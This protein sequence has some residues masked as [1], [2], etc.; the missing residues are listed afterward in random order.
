MT[1]TNALDPDAGLMESGPSE[2]GAPVDPVAKHKAANSAMYA[3]D[4]KFK[5]N[6]QLIAPQSEEDYAALPFGSEYVAPSGEKLR[7][8]WEPK[9]EEDYDLVPEGAEYLTP[10]GE[11][12]T[13]KPYEG[14][15]FTTQ[16]LY[17]MAH[18]D[19][20]RFKVLQ[21]AYPGKVKFNDKNSQ[22]VI[23]DDG[24]Q[25]APGRG[26]VVKTV[27]SRALAETLPAVGMV[28]GFAMGLPTGAA[29]GLAGG[30]AAPVTVPGS[31]ATTAFA[32]SVV[33]QMFGT[34]LNDTILALAGA[35]PDSITE[36]AGNLA[37]SALGVAGGEV[38]GRGVMGGA[39]WLAPRA[40]E[41]SRSA[42]GKV[43]KFMGVDKADPGAL[44]MAIK[45]GE[46]GEQPSESRLLRGLGMTDPGTATT[47]STLYKHSP[48]LHI[49]TEVL[50]PAIH[51][52]KPLQQ[53][54][55]EHYRESIGELLEKK[56]VTNPFEALDAPA[57]VEKV[58]RLQAGRAAIDRARDMQLAKETEL[59]AAK[60]AKEAEILAKHE[61]LLPEGFQIRSQP[62]VEPGKPHTVEIA[63]TGG[64]TQYRAE[65]TQVGPDTWSVGSVKNVSRKNKQLAPALFQELA[66]YVEKQNPSAQ[67][68]A[69]TRA[70][71]NTRA[72]LTQAQQKGV[73]VPLDKGVRLSARPDFE[74][75]ERSLVRSADET[76]EAAQELIERGFKELNEISDLL[77][78]L[79]RD[80][81]KTGDFWEVFG[82]KMIQFKNATAKHIKDTFY[83]PFDKISQPYMPDM[84]PISQAADALYKKL[85]PDFQV[86]YPGVVKKLRDLSGVQNEDGD[87]IK[88]PVQY[89]YG[90][91]HELRSWMR[92]NINWNDF[93]SDIQNGIYKLFQNRVNG[94][95]HDARDIPDM[96]QA[97]KLLDAG[98]KAWRE[99]IG[100]LHTKELQTVI[101]GLKH[102]ME[103][104]PKLLYDT[105]VKSGKTELIDKTREI[106][107]PTMWT[108]IQSQRLGEY[109]TR[110]EGLHPGNID[111]AL[112]A[113]EVLNDHI[114][115]LLKP[116]FREK[117]DM[118]FEHAQALSMLA[119]GGKL[120]IK[121]K[122]GDTIAEVARKALAA[123][124][125]VQEFA[126]AD[127][128]GSLKQA[129]QQ[130]E[131]E[132]GTDLAAWKAERK[133]EPLGFLYES[134]AQANA[135]ADKILENEDRILA[136]AATF[137]ENSPEFDML[138]QVW[139]KRVFMNTLEPHLR[140]K[141]VSPEVQKL[142]LGVDLK[143]A[144]TIAKE[145]QFL[146][147]P[148]RNSPETGA[149]MAATS[150]IQHPWG[151]VFGGTGPSGVGKI[152]KT[153]TA[154]L[155]W[156][157]FSSSYVLG[158]YG[159]Y[160]KLLRQFA[161]SPSTLR[162]FKKGL[163]SK[164][165]EERDF[166]QDW[167]REQMAL[168]G[169]ARGA[170]L[171][172]VVDQ[173][174][175]RPGLVDLDSA[176]L[177][178]NDDGSVSLRPPKTGVPRRSAVEGGGADSEPFEGGGGG[179]KEYPDPGDPAIE[180]PKSP[181]DFLEKFGREPATD[182]ELEF[183]YPD[184]ATI[185]M[186]KTPPR[187]IPQG[188]GL[189]DIEHDD[190]DTAMETARRR[191][192]SGSLPPRLFQK[193]VKT[194]QEWREWL[195]KRDVEQDSQRP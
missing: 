87:W 157:P 18:T 58:S 163:E 107:G 116:V 27:G 16:T 126:E 30:P 127:P 21:Q 23:D 113:K 149:S 106:V 195:G 135:A 2:E 184:I 70:N 108:G 8:R 99:D 5:P 104:D 111:A 4:A 80:G 140:L 6:K 155:G 136:A 11:V 19:K 120:E 173:R 182:S 150:M 90:Q 94:V 119:Q 77:P 89:T 172:E 132:H 141:E 152:A 10:T 34:Y 118:I 165:P 46:Q 189:A 81:Y 37:Q 7:K 60:Q 133:N 20:Q 88:D 33:G 24:V 56:G 151:A 166:A 176:G 38:I 13:K 69:G 47:P 168:M 191:L 78:H 105:I 160:L 79:L 51:T 102:G 36:E 57:P 177:R 125:A 74:L 62:A 76:H 180:W 137:G 44:D 85:P 144:Q 100:P 159:D 179:K 97:I 158:L 93:D 178:S 138:R 154:P 193:Q 185:G 22:F 71:Q 103:A 68:I 194:I 28:G 82:N 32:G 188:I 86:N 17:D 35:G 128:L 45:L 122:P 48:R 145:M 95:L 117:A 55:E 183:Y 96:Q 187:Y 61:T 162:W 129:M 12:L 72:M 83:D 84:T 156:I 54:A 31:A 50:E 161:T 73:A 112:W 39:R 29:M 169:Q 164:N 53:A 26:G 148:L 114:S 134:N 67:L 186:P 92:D 153:L 52:E 142:M 115:G 143:D 25:R 3:S 41:F 147:E 1:D 170:A 42:A 65:L 101:E 40:E 124:K 64:K 123:S 91:L 15:N 75:A 131:K 14:I 59:L 175:N 171:G 190:L 174:S 63:D 9:S 110:A 192:K 146:M 109:F 181:E 43:A 66:K 121:A 98:D 139:L 167:L 49:R 130:I